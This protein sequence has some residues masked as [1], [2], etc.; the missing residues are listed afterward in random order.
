MSASAPNLDDLLDEHPVIRE[1]RDQWK[2]AMRAGRALMIPPDIGYD[3]EFGNQQIAD[4]MVSGLKRHRNG[5]VACIAHFVM[6]HPELANKHNVTDE[7]VTRYTEP[8]QAAPTKICGSAWEDAHLLLLDDPGLMK[9][10]T[11]CYG[12][13]STFVQQIPNSNNLL[14]LLNCR[15]DYYWQLPPVFHEKFEELIQ[16]I[17][18]KEDYLDELNNC[19]EMRMAVLPLNRKTPK[20]WQEIIQKRTTLLSTSKSQGLFCLA[21]SSNFMARETEKDYD[22]SYFKRG[23]KALIQDYGVPDYV[24]HN[25]ERAFY[26]YLR[27][28]GKHKKP[29]VVLID[30]YRNPQDDVMQEKGFNSRTSTW[31]EAVE[32]IWIKK[33]KARAEQEIWRR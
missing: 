30:N 19:L 20:T 21:P 31:R 3:E 17:T 15:V 27:A 22:H 1:Y 12:V 7:E 26:H 5:R 25:A 13:S 11:A 18:A 23:E 2:A 9:I 32:D 8:G 16:R 33:L 29:I 6:N 28:D 10:F 4:F 14:A 24:T